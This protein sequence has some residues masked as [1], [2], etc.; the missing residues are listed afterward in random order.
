VR[1]AETDTSDSS[2]CPS[3]LLFVTMSKK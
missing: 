2:R 1:T 3:T